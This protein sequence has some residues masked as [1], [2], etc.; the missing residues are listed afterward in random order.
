MKLLV[1]DTKSHVYSAYSGKE[2]T[3][4][5]QFSRALNRDEVEAMRKDPS[6]FLGGVEGFSE[7]GEA[8]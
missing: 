7:T 6:A 5:A 1:I 2:R 3:E 8:A 4:H